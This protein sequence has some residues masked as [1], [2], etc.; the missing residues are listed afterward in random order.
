METKQEIIRRTPEEEIKAMIEEK[1]KDKEKI[2]QFMQ[3]IDTKDIAKRNNSIG[4]TIEQIPQSQR[5]SNT[6]KYIE[7]HKHS[8]KNYTQIQ[9]IKEQIGRGNIYTK[10]QIRK[11]YNDYIE[12]CSVM[13]YPITLSGCC[14]Y[15]CIDEQSE[16]A[17][18]INEL[19]KAY[20]EAKLS[21]DKN[22][23]NM[24]FLMKHRYKRNDKLIVETSTNQ[25][26]A[27]SVIDKIMDENNAKRSSTPLQ[28][29][30]KP[31]P[32]S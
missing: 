27:K 31:A 15:M 2:I 19:V 6:K 23:S 10:E 25:Q 12:L 24:Q 30:H 26:T 13:D 3:Y 22:N 21:Q 28:I 17:K 1:E 7:I 29:E 9:Y 20:H 8:I 14:L 18:E 5:R 16:H 4:E 32:W 11:L